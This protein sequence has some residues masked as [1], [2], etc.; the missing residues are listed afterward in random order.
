MSNHET[1]PP[2][3]LTVPQVAARLQLSRQTIYRKIAGGQIPAVQIGPRRSAIRV[4]ED[5][6]EK[7]LRS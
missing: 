5:R 3:L 2:R 4:D 6:L 1:S 7:W